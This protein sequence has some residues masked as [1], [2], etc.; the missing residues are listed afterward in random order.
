M[1]TLN[2]RIAKLERIGL[3]AKERESIG[4]Y[5]KRVQKS[6][7]AVV[8]E[9]YCDGRLDGLA[10]DLHTL[11]AL[12]DDQLA[13]VNAHPDVVAMLGCNAL[14]AAQGARMAE[15]AKEIMA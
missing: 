3:S 4:E 13:R 14:T 6:W 10:A 5:C 15:I 8:L 11:A 12:T 9:S 7:A 1:A 2:D